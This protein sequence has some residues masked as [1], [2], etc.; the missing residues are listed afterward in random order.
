MLKIPNISSKYYIYLLCLFFFSNDL[1]SQVILGIDLDLEP[2]RLTGYNMDVFVLIESKFKQDLNTE[3]KKLSM[4][5]NKDFL[6]NG[7]VT[8]LNNY[9]LTN[10]LVVY[11]MGISEVVLSQRTAYFKE[12]KPLELWFESEYTPETPLRDVYK[13]FYNLKKQLINSYGDPSYE[14]S[15]DEMVFLR[16]D[17]LNYQLILN[18][19]KR[20][21]DLNLRVTY[22]KK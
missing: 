20:P 6:N 2:N 17:K 12:M 8:K 21:E 1:K 3:Y 19:T 11:P 5:I 22:F 7:L 13:S 10:L 14:E 16:W 18:L 15:N 9:G 4:P